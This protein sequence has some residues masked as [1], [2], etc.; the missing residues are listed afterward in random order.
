MKKYIYILLAV[1]VCMSCSS[2][3]SLKIEDPETRA[4]MRTRDEN[5]PVDSLF[6]AKGVKT[7]FDVFSQV[8]PKAFLKDF[9]ESRDSSIVKPVERY[10]AAYETVG[11]EHSDEYSPGLTLYATVIAIVFI[12]LLLYKTIRAIFKNG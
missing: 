9:K 11:K 5:C 1:L 2:R 8:R 6:T 4:S 12:I 7:T 10:K 3:Q